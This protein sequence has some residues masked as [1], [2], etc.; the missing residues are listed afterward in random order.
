MSKIKTRTFIKL[1]ESPF[2]LSILAFKA[3]KSIRYNVTLAEPRMWTIGVPSSTAT[4]FDIKA[5]HDYLE[6]EG[7]KL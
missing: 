3:G 7:F 1:I 6:R 2:V 5:A 4:F